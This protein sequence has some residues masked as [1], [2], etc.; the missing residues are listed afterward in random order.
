[1]KICENSEIC[2]P[3]V[4]RVGAL[5]FA[6]PALTGWGGYINWLVVPSMDRLGGPIKERNI[7]L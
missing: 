3:A 7:V 1:M 4:N 6:F 5:D 2:V